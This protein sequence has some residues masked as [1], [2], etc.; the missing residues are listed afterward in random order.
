MPR[1]TRYTMRL[2][3]KVGGRAE[4]H[5]DRHRIRTNWYLHLHDQQSARALCPGQDDPSSHGDAASNPEGSQRPRSPT[6]EDRQRSTPTCGSHLDSPKA[7][8]QSRPRRCRRVVHASPFSEDPSRP[9]E[10]DELPRS[11]ARLSRTRIKEKRDRRPVDPF[12]FCRSF[13]YELARGR[14]DDSSS[15]DCARM[16]CLIGV[17]TLGTRRSS[18]SL[19][20]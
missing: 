8:H 5:D 1:E 7:S 17:S 10:R 4:S 3:R 19:S 18:E 20:A 6:R 12:F 13:W 16:A 11:E 2:A 9:Q 14:S 15:H